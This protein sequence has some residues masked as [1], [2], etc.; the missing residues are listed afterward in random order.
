MT[1]Q[2]HLLYSL[3]FGTFCFGVW[4]AYA[5]AQT[6]LNPSPKAAACAYNTSLPTA[7]SGSF[8]YVQCNSTGQLLLH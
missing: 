1:R 3:A 4:G 7:T 6:V 8:V 2:R 5:I